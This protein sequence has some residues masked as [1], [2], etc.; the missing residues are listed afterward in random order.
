MEILLIDVLCCRKIPVAYG[1]R[2]RPCAICGVLPTPVSG[3]YAL[4]IPDA[5]RITEWTPNQADDSE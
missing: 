2:I 1:A 5:I 3:P 4:A